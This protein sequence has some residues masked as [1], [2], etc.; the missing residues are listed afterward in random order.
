LGL[1]KALDEILQNKGILYDQKVVNACL[2]LFKE[3]SFDFTD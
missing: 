3:K 1:D 2:T